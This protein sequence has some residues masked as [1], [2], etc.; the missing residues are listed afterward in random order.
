MDLPVSISLSFREFEFLWRHKNGDPEGDGCVFCK[1][2]L[3][4]LYSLA[5]F[6]EICVEIT[7]LFVWQQVALTHPSSVV[8]QSSAQPSWEPFTFRQVEIPSNGKGDSL[9][10]KWYKKETFSVRKFVTKLPDVLCRPSISKNSG[11]IVVEWIPSLWKNSFTFSA[12]FMYSDRFRHRM[13]ADAMIRSPANCQTWN[14]CTAKTP[15]TFSS[16]RFWIA[17][18]FTMTKKNTNQVNSKRAW[19]KVKIKNYLNVRRNCLQ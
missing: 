14:S 6:T 1:I 12:I 19:N 3:V 8:G 13:C 18:T 17:S 15:S 16:K 7:L 5:I 11:W 2:Q 9:K 4:V 10:W